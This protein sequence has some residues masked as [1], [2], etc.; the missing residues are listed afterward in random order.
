[1]KRK[2][3]GGE[4]E[5]KDEGDL[6]FMGFAV[7]TKERIGC[8]LLSVWAGQFDVTNCIPEFMVQ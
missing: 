2:W 6:S 7:T 8:R 5:N 3:W 1:M 4:R